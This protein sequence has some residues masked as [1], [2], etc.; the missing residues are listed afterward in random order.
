MVINMT[1]QPVKMQI[2]DFSA[3]RLL[4]N[5]FFA[6]AL[7]AINGVSLAATFSDTLTSTTSDPIFTI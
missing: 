6:V 2:S 1:T 3:L 7:L 5:F 4:T